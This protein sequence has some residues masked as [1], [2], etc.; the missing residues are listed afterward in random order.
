MDA[1]LTDFLIL[2]QEQQPTPTQDS[3][4]DFPPPAA[5][6][7]SSWPHPA[8]DSS[9][10]FGDSHW[11]VQDPQ[12]TTHDVYGTEFDAADNLDGSAWQG[13][14]SLDGGIELGEIGESPS[15]TAFSCLQSKRAAGC[16]SGNLCL[17]CTERM[18]RLTCLL[19]F[20][21]SSLSPLTH[22]PPARTAPLPGFPPSSFLPAFFSNPT[23]PAASSSTTTAFPNQQILAGPPS[24]SGYD[25]PS[26]ASSSHLSSL[27]PPTPPSCRP[28]THLSGPG[29]LKRAR[30]ETAYTDEEGSVAGSSSINPYA[31][32]LTSGS[33]EPDFHSS[34]PSSSSLSAD[35]AKPKKELTGKGKKRKQLPTVAEFQQPNVDGLSK[36][37]ARLVKNR[38]AAF[39]SRQRKREQFDEMEGVVDKLKEEIAALKAAAAAGGGSATPTPQVAEASPS[40]LSALHADLA[41]LRA[42][43][44][45]STSRERSLEVEVASLRAQLARAA[46]SAQAG[47]GG[48]GSRGGSG[49]G[50]MVS[51]FEVVGAGRGR[52]ERRKEGERD[53]KR[54][55]GVAL[56]VSPSVSLSL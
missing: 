43:L 1:L 27:P 49:Q 56:M 32:S 4:F 50:P 47:A 22:D 51:G 35:V 9:V 26:P 34:T 29:S 33:P 13:G 38:A 52:G 8:G 23:P 16:F 37:E 5:S 42:L 6:S 20:C 54:I 3:H 36:K 39:L 55:G 19:P 14:L 15:N 40:A 28:T 48:E 18:A 2:P 17:P 53:G 45:A 30:E 21:S 7:S 11:G 41:N 10:L 44:H 31:L 25:T 46:A 12:T 24:S